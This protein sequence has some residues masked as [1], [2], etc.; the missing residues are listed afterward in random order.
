MLQSTSHQC[1]VPGGDP[2]PGVVQGD[3]DHVARAVTQ[4]YQPNTYI[5]QH[6]TT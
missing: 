5:T 3:S 1:H 4:H 6:N 2:G